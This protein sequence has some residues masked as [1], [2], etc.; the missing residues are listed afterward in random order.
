[1]R[2]TGFDDVRDEENRYAG[3]I[4]RS[5]RTGVAPWNVANDPVTDVST[6]GNGV[7]I[8]GYVDPNDEALNSGLVNDLILTRGRCPF[9]LASNVQAINVGAYATTAGAMFDFDEVFAATVGEVC[10]PNLAKESLVQQIENLSESAEYYE[11]DENP[12]DLQTKEDAKRLVRSVAPSGLLAGGDVYAYYG[13]VNITWETQRKKLKLIV[14]S[15]Q[16]NL[17]PSLYHGQM[18]DGRVTGSDTERNVTA[19]R[20]RTWLDWFAG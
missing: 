9:S 13:D 2:F 4:A 10:K 15:H 6:F 18:E 20:L 17:Q 11:S 1:M 12:P 3:V 16:K 14:P 19:D 5:L 7:Y 8:V